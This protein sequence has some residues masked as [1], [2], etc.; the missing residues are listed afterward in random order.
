MSYPI[1]KDQAIKLYSHFF[2][3]L[4]NE[5]WYKNIQPYIK[6]T[7]LYGSVAKAT[8]RIDS[9]ID[10]M[11]ILSLAI[12]KKHTD[13]E[14]FL[15]YEGYVFNIVL[16]SIEKLRTIARDKKDEFQSEVFRSSTILLSSDSEVKGLL[17]QL[18]AL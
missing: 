8:N 9:D 15:I 17:T 2:D 12:E 3:V 16:R 7:L 10:S 4:Q 5:D 14:Y 13:G 1:D 18:R 6:A 11:L